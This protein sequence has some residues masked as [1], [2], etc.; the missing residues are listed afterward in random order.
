M[1]KQKITKEMVVEAAFELA[2]NGGLDQVLVKNIAQK[3]NC[4]VQPV[5][6]YCNNMEGLRQDVMKRTERFMQ[7]YLASHIDREDFFRST[8]HAYVRLAKEEPYIF[9][10]FVMHQREGIASLDDLYQTQTNPHMAEFI[11]D[12]LHI[13]TAKARALHLNML[14]YTVGIGTILA[15]TRPG[16]SEE[17]ILSLLEAAYQAFLKQ[18][19]E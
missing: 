9:Q 14:V 13:S 1:P 8:G 10:M 18:A 17:E 11:A 15:T 3:L 5:Y 4:S 7:E 19:L 12:A 16:I 6:S 2:R